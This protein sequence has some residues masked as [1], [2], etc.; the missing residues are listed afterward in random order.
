MRPY[1]TFKLVQHPDVGDLRE[2]ARKGRCGAY[3]ASA[4][5]EFHSLLR[6]KTKRRIRQQLRSR[7]RRNLF[8]D[9]LARIE[10]YQ[11]TIDLRYEDNNND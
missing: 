5:G 9:L 3:K 8:N 4:E 7:D 1:S 6:S 11:E 10:F 2:Q